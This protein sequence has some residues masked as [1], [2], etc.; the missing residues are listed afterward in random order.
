MK[1]TRGMSVPRNRFPEMERYSDEQLAD[2]IANSR[3]WRGVLRAL[4]MPDNS[5]GAARS[6]RRRAH[7]LGLKSDHFTG[8]RR[9]TEAELAAA[10]AGSRTW[11][12]VAST[13]G[14][15]GGSS[16][17]VLRGHALRMGLDTT[18]IFRGPPPESARRGPVPQISLLP[19]AGSMLAAAWYETCGIPVS[20]PLEPAPFD[21]VALADDAPRRVQVKTTRARAR[22]STWRV[23]LS[24]Q[25][26]SGGTYDPDDIDDVFVI[27]ADGGHYVIPFK[28]VAGLRDIHLSAYEAFRVPTLWT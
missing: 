1:A 12:Q 16:A 17:S 23:K 6:A 9:W 8:Q 26:R 28:H 25:T 20:W 2:A 10:V 13:L 14:L 11:S 22:P 4:A 24:S 3:S 7:S 18:H 5:A 21:L 19:R 27:S 15:A